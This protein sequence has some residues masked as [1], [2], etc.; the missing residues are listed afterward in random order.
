MTFKKFNERWIMYYRKI[1]ENA[2]DI[3]I[4]ETTEAEITDVQSALDM[5]ASVGHGLGCRK[6]VIPKDAFDKRF[7]DLS[8]GLAGDILQKFS[9]YQFSVAIVGDFSSYQSA[10]LHSF[11]RESNRGGGIFFARTQAE[12]VS[13]LGR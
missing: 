8:T 2:G 7:F 10:S 9:T 5:M 6:L 13:F 12:A 4:A 11:I 3:A 1:D